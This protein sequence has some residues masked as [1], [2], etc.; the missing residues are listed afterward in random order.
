MTDS[1]ENLEQEPIVPQEPQGEPENDDML[2][3][4]TVSKIVERERLKAFEKGKQE[5]LMELQQQQ[6]NPMQQEQ[7]MQQPQQAPMQ[8]QGQMGGMPQMSQADIE[9]LINERAPQLLQQQLE[10]KAAE[11]KSQQLINDFVAKMQAAEEQYP[12]LEKELN[13]LEY[14]KPGMMELIQLANGMENTG[15]IMK[16]MLDHPM[17]MGGI[18]NLIH[19]QPRK[20][21]QEMAKLSNSIKQNQDALK[22]DAQARDPLSQLRPSQNI[23]QDSSSMSVTDFRKMFR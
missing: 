16:E 21:M 13:E 23:G 15:A 12:G 3:K 18:I 22:E 10:Q 8:Q 4:A 20:A 17:K 7:Q 6:Q 5:A 1:L 11:F 19:T 2:P 9:R 14:D